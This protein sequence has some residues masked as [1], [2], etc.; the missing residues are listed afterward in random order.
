MSEPTSMAPLVQSEASSAQ[1]LSHVA[2]EI[3]SVSE[4][5]CCIVGAGPAGVMLALLLARKGVSVTLLEAH[6]D[7]EREFRGDTLHPIV[8]ENLDQ[9]GL[10]D[11]LLQLQHSQLEK[12]AFQ[13][14]D[15]SLKIAAF[16]QLKTKFPF[17]T[18]IAQSHFLEFITA[19][20]KQYP[21]FHL[22]M[23]A[24]VDT[25][26]EEQGHIRGVRYRGQD[27]WHDLHAV[28]T[29]AADGRFS[30]IRR[31]AGFEPVKSSSPM[32]ILWF[33]ISRT[34]TD[35]DIG[36]GGYF[37]SGALIALIN[38]FDYWQVGYVIPKGGYQ[39]LRSQGLEGVRQTFAKTVPFLADRASEV[40]EWKQVSVLSV[41]SN[42]LTR[43]HR[44]G[45]LLIGDAAH[46]MSPVGGVGINY[47]IQDAIVSA[48]ILAPTLQF[49]I[50]HERDLAAIQ[51]QRVLPT[52]IIQAV[53]SFIQNQVLVRGLKAGPAAT[54]LP[55][56]FRLAARIPFFGMI[57][58]SI[59]GY[60]FFPARIRK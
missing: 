37:G 24:Q 30:R 54:S 3:K 53:Q 55:F 1:P 38:R 26:L 36:L 42:Y 50:V 60:G 27:G 44:P 31:L 33:R 14:G 49:G 15:S 5:T 32:D 11:R 22:I 29:V 12:V 46:V 58:A 4:T 25:L 41:E 39:Q 28:L 48:N 18:V 34:A 13:N 2:P 23:G 10:A 16:N 56:G 43:W 6:M 59:I 9:L 40:Q 7:F 8:M 21:N 47:A 52:R 51:R 17:I 57:P 45:L 20:A 35:P 19:E